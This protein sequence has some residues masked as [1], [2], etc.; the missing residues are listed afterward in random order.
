M[1]GDFRDV[2]VCAV[3]HR[4]TI[5]EGGVLFSNKSGFYRFSCRL[6]FS[7]HSHLWY[8]ENAEST[9]DKVAVCHIVKM[10]KLLEELIGA[11]HMESDGSKFQF[12]FKP[13]A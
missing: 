9:W 8:L 12:A 6:M 1:I 5:V 3:P 13:A 7:Y 11:D 10:H 4:M 2:S